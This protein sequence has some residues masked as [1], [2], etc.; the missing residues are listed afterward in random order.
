[1]YF[2][3]CPNVYKSLVQ[4]E[5]SN[6]MIWMMTASTAAAAT[7][8]HGGSAEADKSIVL[9]ITGASLLFS[10]HTCQKIPYVCVGGTICITVIRHPI[11]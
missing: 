4:A 9:E 1:M 6:E 10:R 8:H 3:E 5:A 11:E 2:D 7:P